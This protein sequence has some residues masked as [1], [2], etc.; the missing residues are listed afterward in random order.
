VDAVDRE[1]GNPD[2]G[3]GEWAGESRGCAVKLPPLAND[4]AGED[5]LSVAEPPAR[6]SEL[7]GNPL[8]RFEPIKVIG[9]S[10]QNINE[11]LP[12]QHVRVVTKGTRV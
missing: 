12:E 6:P 2:V 11:L 9:E 3:G 4:G 5:D 8:S 1:G 7:T 10:K